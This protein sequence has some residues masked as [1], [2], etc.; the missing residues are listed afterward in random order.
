M[1]WENLLTEAVACAVD[2]RFFEGVRKINLCM[3]EFEKS[4]SDNPNGMILAHPEAFAQATLANLSEEHKAA[5]ARMHEVRGDILLGLGATKRAL[6]EFTCAS[7]IEELG[8][9]SEKKRKAEYSCGIN[10]NIDKVPCTII[11]GF[12]G[13]GKTTLLNHI[14]QSQRCDRIAVIKNE[15]GNSVVDD[16]LA[17]ETLTTEEDIDELGNGCKVCT[18]RRDLVV[19]IKKLLQR[20]RAKGKPLN[21]ILIETTGLADLAPV[22]HTFLA[23]SAIEHLC[24][25]DGILALVDAKEIFQHLGHEMLDEAAKHLA[26]KQ[27]AFA[28]RILLNKIDLVDDVTLVEVEKRIRTINPTVPIQRL[29]HTQIDPAYI[30]NIDA[31]SLDKVSRIVDGFLDHELDARHNVISCHFVNGV[32]KCFNMGGKEVF[33]SDVPPGEEPFG[34]WLCQAAQK[35]IMR[36]GLLHLVQ[37]N[38][39]D[40]WVEPKPM[41]ENMNSV[42]IDTPGEVDN[43]LFAEWIGRL[44]HEKGADLIRFRGIVAQRGQNAPFVFH[45]MHMRFWGSTHS[46]QTWQEGEQ[47]RCRFNFIGKKLNREELIGGFMKC[48]AK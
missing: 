3:E 43:E 23:A 38:G 32:V 41:Q 40:I 33:T 28:D 47:R 37:A 45:G 26:A 22:A 16:R 18:V 35:Q 2:Q 42:G 11:T 9:A 7:A 46:R 21:R 48:V 36:F 13:S 44:L 25:L 10:A 17:Q 19:G 24:S 29:S 6:L 30:L 8:T 4:V 5:L 34:P 15:T 12:F 27:L 20:S 1:L 14:L 39:H 31:W